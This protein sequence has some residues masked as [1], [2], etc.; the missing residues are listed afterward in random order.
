MFLIY[1]CLWGN[2]CLWFV[3][4]EQQCNYCRENTE[5]DR[6]ICQ[7]HLYCIL[8]SKNKNKIITNKRWSIFQPLKLGFEM[9]F[10]K[11][12]LVSV[13]IGE[14]WAMCH[15]WACPVYVL[16]C[17]DWLGGSDGSLLFCW[18]VVSCVLRMSCMALIVLSSLFGSFRDYLGFPLR[19][20]S[21]NS[22]SSFPL[23]S[24]FA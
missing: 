15:G 5:S 23:L 7:S 1:L 12:V 2:Q 3:F 13:R 10:K 16:I 22:C 14:I 19:L 21:D 20:P 4:V 18:L 8:F 17:F 6:F 9:Y 11:V 24:S